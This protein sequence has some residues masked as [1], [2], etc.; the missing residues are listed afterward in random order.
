M[1]KLSYMNDKYSYNHRLC[2]IICL[3]INTLNQSDRIF[4]ADSKYGISA[5]ICDVLITYMRFLSFKIIIAKFRYPL[6]NNPEKGILIR[7]TGNND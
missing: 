7:I 6:N 4:L 1:I 2:A 3:Y 5:I